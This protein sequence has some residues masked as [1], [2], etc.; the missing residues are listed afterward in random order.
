MSWSSIWGLVTARVFSAVGKKAVKYDSHRK[1]PSGL[2]VHRI[3]YF[4]SGRN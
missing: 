4:A 2:G 1:Q 3:G